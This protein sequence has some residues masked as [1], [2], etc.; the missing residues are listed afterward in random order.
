ML[1]NAILRIKRQDFT[2]IAQDY[3]EKKPTTNAI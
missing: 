1:S 3:F 2:V